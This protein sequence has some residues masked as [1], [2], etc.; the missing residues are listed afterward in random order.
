MAQ[1]KNMMRWINQYCS[2]QRLKMSLEIFP[3]PILQLGDKI[4]I[5]DKSRGYIQENTNFNDKVFVVS[6]IS[7]SV[8]SDGPSMNIEIVEVGQ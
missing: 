3:N 2:R 8:S 6:S 1:A 4:R 7:H 5:Y